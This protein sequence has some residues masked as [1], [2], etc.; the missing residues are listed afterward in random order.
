MKSLV[1]MIVYIWVFKFKLFVFLF[2]DWGD[3]F[4]YLLFCRNKYEMKY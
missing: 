4:F 3:V 2:D 1:F